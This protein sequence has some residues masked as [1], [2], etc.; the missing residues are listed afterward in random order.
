M[1]GTQESK[2]TGGRGTHGSSGRRDGGLLVSY[3]IGDV[4]VEDLLRALSTSTSRGLRNPT[5]E[6]KPV[7]RDVVKSI[8]QENG[9]YWARM[10]EGMVDGINTEMGCC[11]I[12]A[13]EWSAEAA[14]VR[15]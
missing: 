15:T 1:S 14:V 9:E 13:L 7:S 6:G 5:L 3:S 2:S 10:T 11:G 12:G 8:L 4:R